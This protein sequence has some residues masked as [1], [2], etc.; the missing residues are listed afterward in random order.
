[1]IRDHG[2]TK[3]YY[4]DVEGYNGRLDAIQA[5]I[6][7]IKLAHLTKWNEQRR[8][9]AAEYNR[10]LPGS[11]AL[12]SPDEP[13]WS[14]GGYHLYVVH[15]EDREGLIGASERCQYRNGNSLTNPA[16]SSESLHKTELPR[17]RLPVAEKISAEIVS[18]PMLLQLTA[19]EQHKLV[20]G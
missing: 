12:V 20:G 10:L 17:R 8:K 1:M 11:D 15:T 9:R 4:H 6:L 2:Q 14:R 13:S 5:G 16:S 19:E 7:H 18:L 3:K